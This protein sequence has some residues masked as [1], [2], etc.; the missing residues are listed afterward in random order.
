MKYYS[1]KGIILNCIIN[2]GCISAAYIIIVIIIN[3]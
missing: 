2:I 1:Y 3:V